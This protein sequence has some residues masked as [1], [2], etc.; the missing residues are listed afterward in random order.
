MSVKALRKLQLGREVTAGTAVAATAIWRG[1][2]AIEDQRETVFV[3]EDIGY[4]SGVDRTYVP[5][6]LGALAL[7]S[8]PATYEQL[9]HLL[10]MAIKAIG[11]GAA[12]G[13]GSDKIYD[14]V[15]PTTAANT[16]K[17]Y[18][19]EGGDDQEVE[20]MEYSHA[21][22][23]SLDGKGGE[24]LMMSATLRGRQVAVSAFTGSLAAPTVEE[25][26]F[27][28]GKLY[29][30][31]VASTFGSTIKSNTLLDM[32]LKIT[33]GWIPVW[34]ADGQLYFSFV[35]SVG[36]EVVLSLTFEHDS[37][38]AAEKAKWRAQTP[39][40][41][42]LK[43]V[44]NAVQ[45]AGTTYTTKTLIINLAGKWEKFSSLGEQDGNDTIQGTFRARYNA[46]AAAFGN[47]VVV[48]ELT[49]VP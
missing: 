40:L 38:G 8:V 2:G 14:Y 47:I 37:I 3:A 1:M 43:F 20:E 42:Q 10:E 33:T 49:A 29:I 46:T 6:L 32:G 17:T 13:T 35:K 19:I 41:I 25:I 28:K 44:G 12:D 9:P 23:L 39:S 48:N 4:L 11:T 26:L 45:T 22:D 31:T 27:S 21:Q 30:D 36:P 34:A 18:T 24:A 15:L 16:I 7:D 5:K